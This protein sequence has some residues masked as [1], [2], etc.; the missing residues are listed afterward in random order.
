[1]ST[2]TDLSS[3]AAETNAAPSGGG[4]VASW[5]T[6]N[7]LSEFLNALA[8]AP[9]TARISMS[10]GELANAIDQSA[11][12]N[13]VAVGVSAIKSKHN[14]G[15]TALSLAALWGKWGRSTC[16]I[17]LGSGKNAL[18]GALTG[19]NPDLDA[20]CKAASNGQSIRGLSRLHNQ[21]GNST[22]IA[23]GS[24]DVL[25]LLST[26]AISTLVQSLQTDYNRIVI[27]APAAETGFP[28]LGL[29]KCCERLILSLVQGKT[30]GGPVRE[31]AEQAM[32]LGHRPFDAIWYD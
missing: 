1:M 8:V 28:Y 16:L 30:R 24:A 23:A 32:A 31:L 3:L 20:A 17:D 19:S 29:Y 25:G 22:V 15:L 13:P 27:A 21:I 5:N 4:S 18:G 6:G 11:E 12:D 10:I 9:G 2:D 26:G 7:S 14:L